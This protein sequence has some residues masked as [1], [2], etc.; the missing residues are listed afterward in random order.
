[1]PAR[2]RKVRVPCALISV[3]DK[4]GE[5]PLCFVDC[6][7][8]LLRRTGESVILGPN[9]VR[10]LRPIAKPLRKISLYKEKQ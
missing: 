2:V 5:E 8:L 1:M 6:L 4:S 3:I 7:F 10:V 9:P